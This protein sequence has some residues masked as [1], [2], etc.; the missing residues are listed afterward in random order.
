MLRIALR[1]F[2]VLIVLTCTVFLLPSSVPFAGAEES[3]PAYEPVVLAAETVEPLELGEIAPY[4]PIES[5]YLPD[6]SGYLDDTISVRIQTMRAYDTKVFLTY[7]Q[8]ADAT[9]LRTAPASA[10]T[11][12][13][14]KYRSKKIVN[15]DIIAKRCKAVLA[16]NGDYFIDR[17]EGC[18]VRNGVQLRS[19]DFGVFDCL[20]IDSEG[21]FHILKTPTQEEFEAFDGEILHSFCFGPGLII[22]GEMQTDYN[23]GTMGGTSKKAQRQVICQLGHLSYLI[24]STHGPEQNGSKGLSLKQLQ[25]LLADL[26]VEQA[27]SL[28]GGSSTWLVLD[29]KKINHKSKRGIADIIYF[30][31]AQEA[32]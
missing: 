32:Q 9:Q 24:V 23:A 30:A 27:Y 18:I 5:A 6:D 29:D 4:E 1:I 7:V 17:K 11:F 15:A 22:D 20:I 14:E 26:G 25:E 3:I 31:T 13:P 19:T 12:T 10:N 16:I 28:D 2:A 8:I 21:D